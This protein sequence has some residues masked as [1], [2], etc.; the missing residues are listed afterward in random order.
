MFLAMQY[1]PIH[2]QFKWKN[3][4]DSHQF[5]WHSISVFQ[6][7]KFAC[8]CYVGTAMFWEIWDFGAKILDLSLTKSSAGGGGEPKENL[9]WIKADVSARSIC[10]ESEGA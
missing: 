2:A 5:F 9:H 8:V 1:T 3:K 7:Q 6:E 4:L 10:V